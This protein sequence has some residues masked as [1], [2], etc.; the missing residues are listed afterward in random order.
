MFVDVGGNE[1]KVVQGHQV[2]INFVFMHILIFR[3]ACKASVFC[4]ML[5]TIREGLILFFVM[6]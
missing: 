1:I 3:N 4:M 5:M 2:G 6:R